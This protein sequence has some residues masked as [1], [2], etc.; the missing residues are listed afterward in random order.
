MVDPLVDEFFQSLMQKKE[1]VQ[2]D[3]LLFLKSG[4][5]LGTHTVSDFFAGVIDADHVAGLKEAPLR[6]Q[7][8]TA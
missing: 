6:P 7:E 2:F 4:N 8:K 5:F 3:A 1:M